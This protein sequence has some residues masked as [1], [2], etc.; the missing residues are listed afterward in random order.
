[1][2]RSRRF[3]NQNGWTDFNESDPGVILLE[4]LAYVADLLSSFQDE[5]AAQ[6]RK[7]VLRRFA[8]AL[9]VLAGLVCLSSRRSDGANDFGT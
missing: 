2:P 7:R 1:M 9:G 4:L 5:I 8:I 6:R 3:R